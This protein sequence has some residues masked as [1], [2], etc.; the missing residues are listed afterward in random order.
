MKSILSISFLLFI[1]TIFAQRAGPS[2]RIDTIVITGNQ[3]THAGIILRELTFRKGDTIRDWNHQ[4]EQSRKQLINLFLFNEID[5]SRDSGSIYIKVT[6]RWYIW[7]SPKLDYADRNFNQWWLTRDPKRLIYGMNL[8]W[9]NIRGRNETMV[10]SLISGYTKMAALGYKIPYLNRKKTWGAQFSVQYSSNREVWFKTADEK[11]QF[12]RDNDRV[13]I[14][15]QGMELG[16]THRKRFFTYHYFYA[17]LRST[18]VADTV[19]S[20]SVNRYFLIGGSTLQKESYIGYQFTNDK[21][22]FKGYPLKGRLVKANAEYTHIVGSAPASQANTLMLKLSV[23]KYFRVYGNLFSSFSGVARYYNFD[24]APYSKKQALGY[25]KEYIRGY[26]LS[27]IDG[28][29]FALGKAELKYRFLSKKYKFMPRVKNYEVLPLALYWT[30]YY[31]MG[32]VENKGYFGGEVQ[33]NKLPNAW[34]YGYGTGINVVMFYDYCFR[35]EYS[36]DKFMNNRLY[37]SFVASM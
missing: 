31:D 4:M 24:H 19:V 3:K 27:V 21:R 12:F 10:V 20:D 8:E 15:R 28:S 25:G 1:N 2:F 18:A 34:Q 5:I 35:V 23:A 7:P 32:Y 17:G 33:Q 13:L 6:E 14:R 22:D 37:V 9:Y 36:F 11:V 16:A 30:A 26:E 29:H